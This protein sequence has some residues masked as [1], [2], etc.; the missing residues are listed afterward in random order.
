[1]TKLLIEA[2]LYTISPFWARAER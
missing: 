1:M 2:F